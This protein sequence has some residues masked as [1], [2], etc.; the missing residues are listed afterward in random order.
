[1]SDLAIS[2]AQQGAPGDL[3]SRIQQAKTPAQ[4]AALAGKY[5]PEYLDRQL[6]QA[7]LANTYST[8]AERNRA[9]QAIGV[10]PK[11]LGTTQFKSAQTAQLLRNAVNGAIANV[12]KYG[13]YEKLNGEGKGALDSSK[14]QLR[15]LLSTALEQGV[16]QP[17]EAAAF[18]KS[19][20]SINESPFKRNSVTLGALDSVLKL[21]NSKYDAQASALEGTYKVSREQLDALTGNTQ[22]P[23]QELADMEALIE[24]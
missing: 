23:E 21:A 8:I 18:E 20:G 15:S 17:G 6:K 3:V 9:S 16:V 12:K 2:A 7:Q 13:N 22:I 24:Q 1:V 4:A 11:V 10:S 5:N 14:V 19:I